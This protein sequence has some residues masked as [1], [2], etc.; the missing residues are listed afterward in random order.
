[1]K[2]SK[3]YNWN[4]YYWRTNSRLDV[5]NTCWNGAELYGF[6]AQQEENW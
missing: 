3:I 1:M 5:T 2:D 6:R 4:E